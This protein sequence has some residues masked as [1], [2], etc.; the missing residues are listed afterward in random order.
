MRLFLRSQSR[1]VA[2][3][4]P[5]RLRRATA[6]M[7][8]CSMRPLP[9]KVKPT[10]PRSSAAAPRTHA[11]WKVSTFLRKAVPILAG[12]VVTTASAAPS[13]AAP[14]QEPAGR[15]PGAEAIG[16]ASGFPM[17]TRRASPRTVSTRPSSRSSTELKSGCV[18][19]PRTSVPSSS[20]PAITRA[21]GPGN[22]P[23]NWA[24]PRVITSVTPSDTPSGRR[25]LPGGSEE[26]ARRRGATPT[27]H[28]RSTH[29]R[30]AWINGTTLSD[31]GSE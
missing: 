19:C 12:P 31:A 1:Q 30:P 20:L 24:R 18:C 14:G 5:R 16:V 2:G 3:I 11:H 4:C 21:A 6:A 15:A 17:K 26:T 28:P 23:R 29:C 10:E 25:F 22:E 13:A 7:L 9:L 27:K 8:P